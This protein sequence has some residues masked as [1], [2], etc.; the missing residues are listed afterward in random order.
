MCTHAHIQ[1][2]IHTQCFHFYQWQKESLWEETF[3]VKVNLVHCDLFLNSGCLTKENINTSFFHFGAY[4][5]WYLVFLN[6]VPMIP[7]KQDAVGGLLK[8]AGQEIY[9]RL[10]TRLLMTSTN[11]KKWRVQEVGILDLGV[12]SILVFDWC[13]TFFHSYA[14]KSHCVVS[15]CQF[16][17]TV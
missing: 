17:I 15:K 1:A 12:K 8:P 7:Q 4:E 5:C 13:N 10:V 11:R 9:L 14:K 16:S 3:T 6:W 2:Y